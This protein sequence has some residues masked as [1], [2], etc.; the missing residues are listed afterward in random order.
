MQRVFT[1]LLFIITA[2]QHVTAQVWRETNEASLRSAGERQIIPKKYGLFALNERQLMQVLHAAPKEFTHEARTGNNNIL[3]IP[4]PDGS[5]Q[6]FRVAVSSIM[7]PGL[8]QRV[9]EIRTYAGQGIDDPAATIRLD[10][11]PYYGFHGMILSP[12]GTVFIDPYARNDKEHYISYY[13][14]DFAKRGSYQEQGLD[15]T[16]G[17]EAHLRSNAAAPCRGNELWVYRAAVSNTD[18]YAVAATGIQQPTKQQVL[19]RIVTTMNRVTGVY[20][21]E[22]A[23]RLVLIANNIEIVYNNDPANPD[24]YMGNSDGVTLLGESQSNITTR[25]GAANYDIGHTFSTGAGGIAGLG[26]VCRDNVKARGVT[27]LS[28][29]TG[30]PFDIDYVAHEMG[31][32]FGGNHT[33]NAVFPT[34]LLNANPGPQGTAVEPGSGTTIQGYAGICTTVDNTQPNS[35]P[36]FHTISY[37]EMIN[38][39]RTQN[40]QQR[41]NTGNTPPV[42]TAMFNNNAVIPPSTPFVLTGTATDADGD[43]LTYSW[44]QMD[45]GNGGGLLAGPATPTEPIFRSRVPKLSGSRIFPD[46]RAIVANY[47]INPPSEMNGI[48]GENL[49]LVPREMKFRLTV[50][51]NRTGGGGI[52][53]GGEGCVTGFTDT[54]RIFVAGATPFAVTS[55]NGGETWQAGSV[56][57]ITWN[58]AA[59]NVAPYNSPNVN[60]KLSLDGGFT[61]PISILENTPNDGVEQIT[62]PTSLPSNATVRL[63]VESAE[64]IFFDISNADFTIQNVVLPVALREFNVR[65]INRNDALLSWKTLTE[66]NSRSFDI[67]RS[68]GNSNNFSKVGTIA[69]TGNATTGSDYSFTDKDL[70]YN[71]VIHYRLKQVDVDGRSTLS[72]VRTIRISQKGSSIRVQPNP[73]KDFIR[74]VNDGDKINNA[75]LRIL[76]PDG[77]VVYNRTISLITGVVTADVSMLASGVYTVQVVT[78]DTVHSEKLLKQ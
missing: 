47:P 11:S 43:V 37:D 24:P 51:D 14:R 39:L 54:F 17:D 38:Y 52:A 19:A 10:W 25:I 66:V 20:E 13:K 76:A 53:T 67:E 23:V 22:L 41:I 69:T 26:V 18:E 58:N 71:T 15:I 4:M 28:N 6:R 40:C 35:D 78:N 59:T 21:S 75:Q 16:P 9:P 30:D 61:Y 73:A 29:P 2:V 42:I 34:C 36:H 5:L 50:R 57:T 49:P 44:E 63:L 48:K 45:R 77:K 74:I 33:F 60:I 68:I 72:P 56:Q 62:V 8:E 12:H 27:G 46:I 64:S 70:P 32:Q 31:H 1:F 55:P 65:A 7:E 3:P